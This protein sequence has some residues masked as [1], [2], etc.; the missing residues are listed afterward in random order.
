MTKIRGAD[1]KGPQNS[2][3]ICKRFH[4]SYNGNHTVGGWNF[5]GYSHEWK[6]LLRKDIRKLYKFDENG[7]LV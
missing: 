5:R 1:I 2:K 4:F 7:N 6:N 3:G